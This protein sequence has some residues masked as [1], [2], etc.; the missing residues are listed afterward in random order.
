MSYNVI[1]PFLPKDEHE[2]KLCEVYLSQRRLTKVCAIAKS[3]S[4]PVALDHQFPSAAGRFSLL[5]R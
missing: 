4:T 5:E 2:G 1:L 3:V